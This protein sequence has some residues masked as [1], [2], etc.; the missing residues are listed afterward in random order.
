MDF[1]SSDYDK[2]MDINLKG[3]FLCCREAM[4]LMVPAG[5]GYIINISS[6]VGFKGYPEQSAYTASKHGVMGLTKSLS[7][8]AQEHNIRVSVIL[9]GG[10]DTDLVR[11]ARPDL[12][13]TVLIPPED[14][15]DTVLYLLSLSERAVVDQVYIRRR[16]SAPF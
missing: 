8:E 4:R 15:A 7:V 10:V 11:A 2:I 9:P 3:V 1:P 5:R 13:R 16:N 12:D 14:I 6:V